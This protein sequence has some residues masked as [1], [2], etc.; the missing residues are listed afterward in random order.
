MRMFALSLAVVD[1]EDPQRQKRLWLLG[2]QGQSFTPNL[3]HSLIQ[4]TEAKGRGQ[5][6]QC[7]EKSSECHAKAGRMGR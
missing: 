7:Q 4:W 5:A 6:V 1:G 3:R 2:V